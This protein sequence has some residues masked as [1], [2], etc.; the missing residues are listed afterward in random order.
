[1]SFPNSNF[2]GNISTFVFGKY[3]DII[4]HWKLSVWHR[5]IY[6]AK[7]IL[8]YFV[9]VEVRIFVENLN[10]YEGHISRGH[11]YKHGDWIRLP[12]V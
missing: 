4:D 8:N 1:M 6:Y 3:F 10:V 2:E 9:C 12:C 5:D 7:K 11:Y